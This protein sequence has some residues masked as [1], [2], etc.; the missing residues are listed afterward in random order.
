MLNNDSIQDSRDRFN[1]FERPNDDFPFYNGLPIK[2]T[3]L[4]WLFVM[5][6]VVVGFVVFMTPFEF[7]DNNSYVPFIRAILFFTIPL[8][9]LAIVAKK[10]W[11]AIFRKVRGKD[12]GLMF[13][14]AAINIV[15]SVAIATVVKLT[16]GTNT[17]AAIAGLGELTISE[18]VS[19]FINTIP[20]LFGEEVMTILPFLALMYV[21]STKMKL[22]RKKSI[23]WAWLISAVMFGLVHLT[24]YDWNFVQ[25]I[26]V[27]GSARLI[28]SL[29]YIKTK[30]IWVSTGAHII[31]D[32]TIF[33]ITI[34]GAATLS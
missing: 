25:C 12:V 10:H 30:N 26:V 19:F 5:V 4:Q 21:F 27:I 3:G 32:W 7:L 31:N 13:L 18:Q 1:K 2:I 24:M 22:S 16:M 9:G 33:I 29:A 8:A 20:S 34:L 17:N 11:T 14:F 15:V 6:M 23:V 28:L